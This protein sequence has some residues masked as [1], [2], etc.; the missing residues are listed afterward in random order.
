MTSCNRPGCGG[1]IL[2]SGF[3]DTCS[4]QPLSGSALE[5]A[6]AQPSLGDSGT[7]PRPVTTTSNVGGLVSLPALSVD[8]PSSL[9]LH[10]GAALAEDG[11]VCSACGALVGRSYRGQEGLPDGYCQQC[12]ARY[13][14]SLKLR[15]GDEVADRYAVVGPLARGGLGWVYLAH[16]LHLHHPVVLKGLINTE[17]ERARELATN[18][19]VALTNLDHP[20]LVRIHD[21]VQHPDPISGRPTDYIVMEYVGGPAL[22]E[23]RAGS[24]WYEK[25]G[26]VTSEHVITYVL[27]ILSALGYLHGAGLLYCDMK[28]AN[29]I[30]GADRLKV[31]D[32]GAVRAIDDRTTGSVGTAGY[33]ISDEEV[34]EHGFSVRSDLHT[35]GRTLQALH[36]RTQDAIRDQA[37]P[38]PITLGLRSLR[39]VYERALDE[40]H[41]RFGSTAEMA[42]QL[43]G[44]LREIIALRGGERRSSPS[45]VF[46]TPVT[47]LDDGLGAVP[48][49]TRWTEGPS[50]APL[51]DGRPPPGAVASGLPVP[52]VRADDP[53]AAYLAT[54]TVTEP[55]A[56]LGQLGKAPER[57]VEAHLRACRVLVGEGDT[58]GAGARLEAAHRLLGGPGAGDWQLA[59]HR[60]LVELAA[61]DVAAARRRFEAV[62]RDLPGEDAP[63]LAV[64]YCA[65]H[66]GDRSVAER[67]YEAVWVRERLQVSAAFGLARVRLASVWPAGTGRDAAVRVL[68]EVG[69]H[70]QHVEAAR[71]AAIMVRAGRLPSGAEE[72][73][74][75][76]DVDLT[77]AVL[78]LRDLTS[79]DGGEPDGPLRAR[80]TAVLRA[81]AWGIADDPVMSAVRGGDVLGDPPSEATLRP[82]LE[83]SLRGL[84]EQAHSAR[85][86]G[87][88]ID[89]ANEIRPLTWW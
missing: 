40:H 28:P 62:Y 18:E 3:C 41:R 14:F 9:V 2:D 71:I 80:L 56:L 27:E 65:E 7:Q 72:H 70:S 6:L 23:L 66:T 34:A 73:R 17:D 77:E 67:F 45:T 61:G 78:R 29:A 81:A 30:R 48:P 26:E 87:V 86:H 38:G 53:G 25:H 76:S 36:Q 35:V 50:S 63:K 83:A 20:N 19:R 57:S 39:H 24:E 74:R 59:W 44:V 79:L 84:A 58:D 69:E 64:G 60:G 5:Q 46:D 15:K 4:R 31:I 12:G 33:R 49:L 16:D 42:E 85:D 32:F 10:T 21:F 54:V 51:A 55:K 52:L 11:R 82:L 1:T 22:S 89:R 88:L 43:A 8:D 37:R 47:L 13:S 68:D 75:P